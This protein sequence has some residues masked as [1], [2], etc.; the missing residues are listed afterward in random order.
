[1]AFAEEGARGA[2]M[3]AEMLSTGLVIFASDPVVETI[4]REATALLEN[5][6]A[7]NRGSMELTRYLT[8]CLYEDGVDLISEDPTTASMLL[9]VAVFS[10]LR[11]FIIRSHRHL[12]SAKHFLEAVR[13]LDREIA[14]KT[15]RFFQ[16][17]N[18]QD[19]LRVASEIADATI[20]ARGFFEW[21]GEAET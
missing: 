20:G 18:L 12:P 14:L 8:A 16:S 6:P 17:E 19:R 2:P 3:T 1:K 15:E 5:P 9:S 13:S 10:M 4:R 21:S 7:A 11:C